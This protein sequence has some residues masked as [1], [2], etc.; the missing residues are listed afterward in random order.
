MTPRARPLPRLAAALV[1]L[2]ASIA[3]VLACLDPA[4][5]ITRGR[6][7]DANTGLRESVVRI[8]SS[9]GELCTGVLVRDDIVLTAAHCV[10]D[11][12]NYRVTALDYGFGPV[13]TGVAAAILHPSFQ[14]GIPPREQPGVDLALLK[15]D[16]RLGADFAPFAVSAAQM[17]RAGQ[18]ATIAGF[19]TTRF[20]AK[21]TARTLRYTYVVVMGEARLGNRMIMAAD[22]ERL[23][24]SEGA[25][26]CQGDSG[27]PLLAGGPGSYRLDGIV[28]W[29]SGAFSDAGGTACGGLTAI[30]PVAPHVR[31][32]EAR[33][34]DLDRAVPSAPPAPLDITP[35]ARG[36]YLGTN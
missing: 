28:S 12:V 25:G 3:G 4:S 7:A 16:Q 9:D 26:A 15:L 33:I 8:D 18:D 19:G 5:A 22:P 36:V 21:S 30:T 31:W 10:L 34:G 23:G 17:P 29:S 35:P 32:I 2:A 6:A 27:G 11:P 24:E 13:R 14:P 20:R 1:T